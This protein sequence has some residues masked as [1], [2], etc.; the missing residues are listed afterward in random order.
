MAL[1]PKYIN[2]QTWDFP[3][4]AAATNKS[5][6]ILLASRQELVGMRWPILVAAT[7]KM[8]FETTEDPLDT[9]DADAT[10]DTVFNFAGTA[11]QATAVFTTADRMAW[12]PSA[13]IIGGCRVRLV[14]FQSNGT[15]AVNQDEQV[16][17]PK[18]RG[19][20]R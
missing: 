16:V 9:S 10:W 1:D 20:G 7:A 15:A 18:F 6:S 2:D 3:A 8:G 12:D 4:A 13:V 14:A 17:I 19:L 5:S 11:V